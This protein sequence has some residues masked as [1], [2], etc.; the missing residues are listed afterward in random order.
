M[1]VAIPLATSV[2]SLVF[3][4][5]LLD[6]YLERRWAYQLLW[7]IGLILYFFASLLQAI[8]FLG[9]DGEPIFRLWYL[10]GAMLVAAYLGMGSVYLQVPRRVAQGV[11]VVL[12]VTTVLAAILAL[13]T[14][15]QGEV[16]LLEGDALTSI[17][18][19]IENLRYYP[20]N[21]GIVTIL[22]NSTGAL[23]LV[24][25]AVYSAV[26]F[27]RQRAPGYRVVSNVLIAVG[28]TISAA[29]GTLERFDVPEPHSVALLLGVVII[30]VGFLRSREVFTTYR[31]PFRRRAGQAGQ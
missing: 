16:G 25:F 7:S 6:Q 19:G 28:A 9:V 5:T 31:I 23:A 10:T 4:L 13:G 30:Y 22:L 2:V 1:N 11:M 12:L 29:G 14:Q 15:L 8:W 20:G 27:F 18:P 24:G 3:A 17:V 26:V 21:V